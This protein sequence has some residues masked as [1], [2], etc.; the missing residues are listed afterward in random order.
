MTVQS[1]PDDLRRKVRRLMERDGLCSVMNDTKWRELCLEMYALEPRPRFRTRDLLAPPDYVSA[2]DRE[3]Y[4]HP[5]PYLTI[6]WMEIEAV[7]GADVGP[8]TDVL[9]RAGVPFEGTEDRIRVYGYTRPRGQG[10]G[11]T[12]E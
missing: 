12:T 3:W 7:A 10:G 8:I 9:R 5:Q 4:Y 2:W 6:E 1:P 11:E